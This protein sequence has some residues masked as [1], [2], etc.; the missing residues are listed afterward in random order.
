MLILIQKDQFECNDVG[1]PVVNSLLETIDL[2]SFYYWKS[3]DIHISNCINGNNTSVGTF[4]DLIDL[5]KRYKSD[6]NSLFLENVELWQDTDL[7]YL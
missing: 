4:D 6:L 7:L 5:W 2:C 1:I 3:G